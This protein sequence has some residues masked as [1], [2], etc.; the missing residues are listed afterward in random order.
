MVRSMESPIERLDKTFSQYLGQAITAAQNGGQ[1]PLDGNFR[2]TENGIEANFL[3]KSPLGDVVFSGTKAPEGLIAP[4]ASI[5]DPSF[6]EKLEENVHVQRK[7]TVFYVEGD[8][9]VRRIC[10]GRLEYDPYVSEENRAISRLVDVGGQEFWKSNDY[11]YAT[12]RKLDK[13][14]SGGLIDFLAKSDL[15]LQ[16]LEKALRLTREDKKGIKAGQQSVLRIAKIKRD[17]NARLRQIS[18]SRSSVPDW[19]DTRRFG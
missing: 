2:S 12:K 7:A 3:L 9:L 15:A 1:P 13:K 4:V 8:E 10:F 17:G 11:T 19:Y 6:N 18:R 14:E 16:G 5:A